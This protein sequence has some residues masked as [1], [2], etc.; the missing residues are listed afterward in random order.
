MPCIGVQQG[1]SEVLS[2]RQLCRARLLS[3]LQ[4]ETTAS[5]SGNVG[6]TKSMSRTGHAEGLLMEWHLPA[7]QLM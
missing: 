6:N 1:L 7:V 5:L 4:Q 2:T 3:T